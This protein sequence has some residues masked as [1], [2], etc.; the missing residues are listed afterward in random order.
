MLLGCLYCINILYCIVFNYTVALLQCR[1]DWKS[2]NSSKTLPRDEPDY[3]YVVATWN[4]ITVSL[5]FTTVCTSISSF[6][7]R[8]IPS[9]KTIFFS[10]WMLN[11]M[12]SA[13]RTESRGWNR[14]YT[15]IWLQGAF[16]FTSPSP[17]HQ[18]VTKLHL[19]QGDQTRQ[20][21]S[22]TRAEA[23]LKQKRKKGG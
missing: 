14:G 13:D 3:C 18:S 17:I 11:S 7:N 2:I 6:Q 9:H 1:P 19:Q 16:H 10:F 15:S 4:L 12:T 21:R 23:A 5:C 22:E 8:N 20:K